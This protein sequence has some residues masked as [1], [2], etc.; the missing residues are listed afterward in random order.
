LFDLK[1]RSS[2]WLTFESRCVMR[3]LRRRFFD[4]SVL[5]SARISRRESERKLI[6]KMSIIWIVNS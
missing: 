4:V 6:E 2:N 5:F 3:S 1:M